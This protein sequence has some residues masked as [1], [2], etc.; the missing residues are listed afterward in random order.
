M[1]IEKGQPA[2]AA[3]QH[4][5]GIPA[6][7]SNFDTDEGSQRIVA[8]KAGAAEPRPQI[9]ERAGGKQAATRD[10]LAHPGDHAHNP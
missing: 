3:S 4:S 6:S 7:A 1:R 10:G 5:G 8:A 9:I 2:G